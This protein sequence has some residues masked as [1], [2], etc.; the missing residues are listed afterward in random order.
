MPTNSEENMLQKSPGK[1]VTYSGE[2]YILLYAVLLCFFLRKNVVF[3][4]VIYIYIYFF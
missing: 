3:H 4:Y 2:Q 1:Y